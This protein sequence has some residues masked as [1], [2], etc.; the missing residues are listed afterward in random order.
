M[1]SYTS[2]AYTR[3]VW[4]GRDFKK[5][6]GL[7]YVRS[8][9]ASVYRSTKD[10]TFQDTARTLDE[11]D[12]I[13]GAAA[14]FRIP[15]RVDITRNNDI[16]DP[17]TKS[18]YLA[19]NSLGLQPVRTYELLKEELDVWA[20]D[21]VNGH[22]RHSHNRPWLSIDET[23]TT[24]M[25]NVVGAKTEEVAVM[26]T[27][28]T[29]LH[30]LLSAFYRPTSDRYKIIIENKAFPSDHYA[31][32]SQ[33]EIH[34]YDKADALVQIKPQEGNYIL[35]TQQILDTITEH[36]DNT[37]LLLLPG[38]QY[39]TGQAFEVEKITKYAQS[40]GIIV[41]WD[42]AHAAGNLKLQLHDWNVDFAVWCTYKYLNSG[43]GGIGGLFVHEKNFD[44]PRLTGWWAHEKSTRFLMDNNFVPGKGASAFQLSNPSVLDTVALLAS[45]EVFDQYGIAALRQKSENLTGFLETMLKATFPVDPPFTIIT[46]SDPAQRGAQLS[47][48][49]KPGLMDKVHA[50]LDAS[51]ITTDERKPDVIRVAPTPLY[52]SYS[53]V[54][55][56][57]EGLKTALEAASA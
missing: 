29:N 12:P 30:L 25:A 43:P 4:T 33:I 5:V 38:I 40:L 1:A 48:L 44:R 27:L 52:N 36:A 35:P 37:A 56:F 7:Q 22:F 18:V 19:G 23:V 17:H 53:D 46:P 16:D 14:K 8:F 10:G 47:L 20:K 21:G 31:V 55:K 34:G 13:A 28:T 9:S 39:Y 26:S 6:T 41:G 50:H 51:A 49:F 54:V 32:E 15:S 24:I 45:L 2:R 3:C 57:V 11:A 42:M